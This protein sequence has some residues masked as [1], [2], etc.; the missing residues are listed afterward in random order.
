MK[1][2]DRFSLSISK[3]QIDFRKLRQFGN[4]LISF[5][6][7]CERVLKEVLVEHLGHGLRPDRRHVGADRATIPP[8]N[9]VFLRVSCRS[10]DKRE[11]I[12]C[13]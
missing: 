1:L 13:K 4:P 11:C 12:R 2:R 7:N 9:H 3:F 5:V 10:F 8:A 6:D